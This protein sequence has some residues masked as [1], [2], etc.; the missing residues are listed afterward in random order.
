MA[1]R[2][3]D[4]GA[5]AEAMTGDGPNHEVA[6]DTASRRPPADLAAQIAQ[7]RESNQHVDIGRSGRGTRPGDARIGNA[8]GP[9]V[10]GPNSVDPLARGGEQGPNVR[11]VPADRPRG[12]DDNTLMP[13]AVLSRIMGLYL[14]QLQRCYRDYLR[15]DASARGKVALVFTVNASGRVV[16]AHASG[17]AALVDSCIEVRMSGWTFPA[18]KA[19]QGGEAT[20]AS[21]DISLQLVPE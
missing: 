4:A 3:V 17:V 12:G 11:V 7:A 20:E 19:R 6:S 10:D 15:D 16:D 14:S 21:F 8:N 18:P 2:E 13:D 9:V 1:R 5:F